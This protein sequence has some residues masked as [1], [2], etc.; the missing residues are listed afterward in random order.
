M[1]RK[2]LFCIVVLMVVLILIGCS[3]NESTND[4]TSSGEKTRIA[5]VSYQALDSSE[6]LQNLVV[7]LQDYE[8]T[9]PNV[10]IKCIEALSIDQYEPKVRA[11]CE[12]GFD[13]I[14]TT[15]ADM[16]AATVAAAADYPDIKFGILQGE[17]PNIA[18]YPNIADFHLN[19]TETAFVQGCAA[20]LMTKTG[21]VGFVGGSDS[22]G[23]NEILAGYQQ[24]IAYIDD[25]V[26]DMVAYCNSFT[27]PTIGKDYALQLIAN[28]CDV[29][30]GAAGGSSTGCAQAAEESGVMYAACDVHYPDVAANAEIGS[31]LNYF[32]NMVIAFIDDT[33]AGDYEG[34]VSKEY[35]IAQGA[36]K[37][38]FA[39]NGI[40]PQEIQDRVNEIAEM[41]GNG[42]IE[43]SPTP[44]H[45]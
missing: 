13:I 14:I 41:V 18:D 10:E 11:C 45:K 7:G 5:F 27:D 8:K 34:G 24:G 35:G 6:W 21:K 19:R 20:A 23:I 37:Y 1:R 39:S 31:A 33:L 26:V 42:E 29:I 44:L 38:E 2:S 28:G 30:F 4:E 17:M 40:V 16:S 12:N 3:K 25:S 36:A 15:Y 9:H 22:G 43:I 32:E